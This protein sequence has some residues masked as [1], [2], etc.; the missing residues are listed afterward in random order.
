MSYL[1]QNTTNTYSIPVSSLLFHRSLSL[2]FK[3]PSLSQYLSAVVAD[4]YRPRIKVLWWYYSMATYLRNVK[5]PHTT[6]SPPP[7]SWITYFPGP[8][9]ITQPMDAPHQRGFGALEDFRGRA[10]GC[11]SGSPPPLT[12]IQI[13][14]KA[15]RIKIFMRLPMKYHFCQQKCCWKAHRII[16]HKVALAASLVQ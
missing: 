6:P 11:F 4:P 7:T 14:G 8:S 9:P 16:K 10:Q 13:P 12:K 1:H 2:I 15:G 5:H 3:K